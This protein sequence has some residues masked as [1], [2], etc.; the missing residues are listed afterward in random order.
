MI[1]PS[2]FTLTSRL[3]DESA[4]SEMSSSFLSEIENRLGVGFDFRGADFSGY[5]SVPLPLIYVRTGGT[6][7]LFKELLP[8][9]GGPVYLLTSG[10]SNSLAASMEILS[11]LCSHGRS[12]EI[13]HGSIDVIADRINILSRV[14]GAVSELAGSRYGVL[15]KPSDWLIS[16]EAD[17]D[18][19]KGK[20]GIEIVDVP[21]GF[22]VEEISKKEYPADVACRILPL[23]GNCPSGR[24]DSNAI[25]GA[26]C[27]YGA[28]K[29]VAGTYGLSGLTVR[30]FDLLES[31]GNTGCLALAMLNQEGL[32]S[33]CEGDIPAMVTMAVVRA[34]TGSSGFQSNPSRIDVKRGEALFAHCTIPL[35]MVYKYDYDSHFESGTGVAIHGD[36]AP[37]PVTVFKLSGDLSRSFIAEGTLEECTASSN[38]C[39]TQLHLKMEDDLSSLLTSPVGNHQVI[40]SGRW[41]SLFRSFMDTVGIP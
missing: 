28:M 4:V 40:V 8:R 16:S 7:G 14:A 24:V 22:L 39:R 19:I 23:E 9:I 38:L 3:H 29:R 2:I 37:G 13:I 31:V 20:L 33:G 18:L 34:L 15:G 6:E 11:Y 25:D 1:Q 30:C 17:R 21:M 36:V 41:K 32:V 35:N 10:S 26:L 5:S 12:G 27:I